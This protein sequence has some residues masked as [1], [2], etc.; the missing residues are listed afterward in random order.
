MVRAGRSAPEHRALARRRPT[1][2]T[3]CCAAARTRLGIAGRRHPAQRQGLLEPRLLRHGLSDQRQAV[4]AGHD[5]PDARSITARRLLVQTRAP[6]ASSSSGGRVAALLCDAR[7]TQDGSIV[8]TAPTCA[9]APGTSS[10]PA[11]RSTRRRCCCARSVPDPHGLLGK[12]TFLHPAVISAALF[13]QR[14][15]GWPARRSRSTRTTSSTRGADRRC[16]SATSSKRRRC[17]RCCCRHDARRLRPGARRGDAASSR[18]CT[19]CSRCCATASIATSPGGAV[20][21][22]G[23]GSPVLDYPLNDFIWDGARRALLDDGRD[24]VRGRRAQRCMPV[25]EAAPQLAS[26]A[27]GAGGRSPRLP[28][29]PLLTRVVSAHVMG[30]CPMAGDARRGVVRPDGRTGS[31]TICRCTTARCSRPASAP[32]RSCRSTASSTGSPRSSPSG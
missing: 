19:A 24:P 12:R 5:D 21:L 14:V 1:R 22:R 15:E 16:R 18:T 30:G 11:A 8:S 4:D 29:R 28:L 31:S 23:D 27:R 32:I 6:S 7:S 13:E 17:I 9:C 20:R 2:T 26:W 25:H 10:S 3:T